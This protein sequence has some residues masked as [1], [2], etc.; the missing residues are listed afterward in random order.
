MHRIVNVV[1]VGGSSRPGSTAEQALRMVLDAA[2]HRGA[3]VQLISGPS[4]AMPLY[5]PR[6]GATAPQAR[7]LLSAIAGADGLV[8]ASPAYHGGISGLVKNALD[9]VEELREDTRPYFSERAV[10]CVAV[11]HGWQGAVTT[12]AALRDVTHA[13]RGWPTP[14]GAAIN[15]SAAR[16]SLTG[17]CKDTHVQGQLEEI[18]AQVV[19]FATMRVLAASSTES[20]R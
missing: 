19:E 12:L 18:A 13:L 8:L 5:D 11:A 15:T 16:F 17:A 14:L 10:G 7:R 20:A 3:S 2:Q 1:G 6:H 4:L 9:H